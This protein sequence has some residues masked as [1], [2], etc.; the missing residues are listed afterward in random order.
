MNTVT[1]I[2]KF[3]S[4]KFIKQ[5]ECCVYSIL[6]GCYV[7][8]S[9]KLWRAEPNFGLQIFKIDKCLTTR[10]CLLE[11]TIVRYFNRAMNKTA[12]KRLPDSC[13][14]LEDAIICQ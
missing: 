5:K 1:C 14:S 9:M 12:N 11:M 10:R 6:H 3:F 7:A 13:G 8:Y 4:I 2:Q